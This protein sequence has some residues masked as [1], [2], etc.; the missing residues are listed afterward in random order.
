MF[1][2]ALPLPPSGGGS[3]HV[4][5]WSRRGEDGLDKLHMEVRLD[6]KD[7]TSPSF[8][9]QQH[10]QGRG[11]EGGG[12]PPGQTAREVVERQLE[13]PGEPEQQLQQV[14]VQPCTPPPR[15]SLK[16]KKKDKKDQHSPR[17]PEFPSFWKAGEADKGNEEGSV[18]IGEG[19]QDVLEAEFFELESKHD[20]DEMGPGACVGLGSQKAGSVDNGGKGRN[21]DAKGTSDNDSSDLEV[22]KP[23]VAELENQKAKIAREVAALEA[24]MA[25]RRPLVAPGVV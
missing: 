6:G 8:S 21:A 16:Q 17:V 4:T 20:W 7:G 23:E 1:F 22:L 19:G 25:A 5:A 13:H 2:V 14:M 3:L 18:D 10:Q 9:W 12:D 11:G 15:R 24:A